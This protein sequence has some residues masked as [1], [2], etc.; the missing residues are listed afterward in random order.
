MRCIMLATAALVCFLAA[1]CPAQVTNEAPRY[2]VVRMVNFDKSV[3]NLAM[4]AAQFQ[5]L[6]AELQAEASLFRRALLDASNEWKKD[7]S[8][9]KQSFPSSAFAAR[10]VTV[11]GQMYDSEQKAVAALNALPA[12]K[13]RTDPIR[14]QSKT[15][16]EKEDIVE[17][18]MGLVMEALDDL[19]SAAQPG[20]SA[21]VSTNKIALTPGQLLSRTTAGPTHTSYHIAVPDNFNPEKPPPLLVLFSPGG[22]GREIMN[23]VRAS[24]NKFGW[25]VIGCDRLQNS[26]QND[27]LPIEKDLIHDFRMFIPYD[28][29]RLYYGGF[30]GGALRAY[31][32]TCRIKDK[33]AGIL[34]FGGWLGGSEGQKRPFQKKMAIAMVNGKNDRGAQSWEESDVTA[35]KNRQCEVKA[36][37]FQ[38]DHAVAPPEVINEAI[39]WL[40]KQGGTKSSHLKLTD[41]RG[42]A[43]H[44]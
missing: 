19:K 40:D 27:S 6:N 14:P 11:I 37:H 10:Q 8:H 30:S 7:E 22:D 43:D 44:Q 41:K 15:A 20:E 42:S 12:G 9:R 36:F 4:S 18:A 29:A 34:A 2:A 21:E 35:L 25:M 24:A 5:A 3:T 33:C 1:F 16:S 31:I 38:G 26:M 23:Q 28:P 39:A 32:L 17:Q 13:P